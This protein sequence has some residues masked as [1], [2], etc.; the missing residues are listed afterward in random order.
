MVSWLEDFQTNVGGGLERTAAV[1]V[2]GARW[3]HVDAWRRVF[4]VQGSSVSALWFAARI[5]AKR[6]MMWASLLI[7]CNVRTDKKTT[8]YCHL[9]CF[10]IMNICGN[11]FEK[12]PVLKEVRFPLLFLLCHIHILVAMD[13]VSKCWR[14][15][16]II[17]QSYRP[18]TASCSA[19][20]YK[21]LC[22]GIFS[23]QSGAPCHAPFINGRKGA[24]ESQPRTV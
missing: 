1:R 22:Y 7:H 19:H 10:C 16:D 5:L 2:V 6:G 12:L 14:V 4:R 8:V 24:I 23:D 3:C 20:F 9:S 17:L 21:G 11:K 13:A 18:S 15:R